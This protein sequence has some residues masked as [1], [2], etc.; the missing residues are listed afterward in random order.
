MVFY[1]LCE[2]ILYCVN[3]GYKKVEQCVA[4]GFLILLFQVTQQPN[5]IVRIQNM[6]NFLLNKNLYLIIFLLLVKNPSSLGGDVIKFQGKGDGKKN[7]CLKVA[8]EFEKHPV[9]G[10]FNNY[11]FSDFKDWK[12]R[13]GNRTK[14]V[15]ELEHSVEINALEI[16]EIDPPVTGTEVSQ[17]E[18]ALVNERGQTKLNITN[19]TTLTPIYIPKILNN[20]ELTD[21]LIYAA[22]MNTEDKTF[23]KHSEDLSTIVLDTKTIAWTENSKRSLFTFSQERSFEGEMKIKLNN[24]E[25][26]KI[27]DYFPLNIDS[28]KNLAIAKDGKIYFIKGMK[29]NYL[30]L[31]QRLSKIKILAIRFENLQKKSKATIIIR[32]NDNRGEERF[33]R[34]VVS[35]Y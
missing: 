7:A 10:E 20:K 24:Y 13:Y 4:F 33:F 25:I 28:G 31:D 21:H 16:H 19:A 23:L 18:L 2:K 9:K 35:V 8:T 12:Y 17:F 32:G 1:Q 22:Q 11:M 15:D 30:V 5:S 6:Q 34:Y 26:G 14:L 29:I 3:C 27:D